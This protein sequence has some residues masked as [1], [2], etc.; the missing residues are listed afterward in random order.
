MKRSAFLRRVTAGLILIPATIVALGGC[1]LQRPMELSRRLIIEAIGVDRKDE[2][3]TLTL[4]TLDAYFGSGGAEGGDRKGSTKIYS[5][6]GL[7]AADALANVQSQTGLTP[8]YSQV[9]LLVLSKAAADARTPSLLTYF[10]RETKLRPD[11]LICI[12]EHSAAQIVSADLDASAG[13]ASVLKETL[14]A[15]HAGGTAVRIP[16]Y[17]FLSLFYEAGE[18]PYCPLVDLTETPTDKAFLLPVLRGTAFLDENGYAVSVDETGTA[19]LLFLN[20]T[21]R[22]TL[23]RLRTPSGSPYALRILSC[24][25]KYGLPEKGGANGVRIR[26]RAK[27]AIVQYPDGTEQTPRALCENAEAYLREGAE[28]T[29]RLL[30]TARGYDVCRLKK[31]AAQRGLDPGADALRETKI[32]VRL[33]PDGRDG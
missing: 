29:L 9:K 1:V 20:G 15:G 4:Q 8:L 7:T 22:Q 21:M 27:C 23:L 26:I 30:Y 31:R 18:T 16:L 3:Y 28:K 12:A 11:T 6:S 33:T 17:R 14:E 19:F 24:S 13:A 25:T 5:F 2:T 10:V 32:E